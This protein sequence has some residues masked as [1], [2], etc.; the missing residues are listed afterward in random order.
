MHAEDE[1]TELSSDSPRSPRRLPPRLEY[2]SVVACAPVRSCV[3]GL[4]GTTGRLG[5][6]IGASTAAKLWREYM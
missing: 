5:T 4:L 1:P 2:E 3:S 6:L